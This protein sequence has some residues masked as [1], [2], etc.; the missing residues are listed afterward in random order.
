MTS[1][2]GRGNRTAAA[3]EIAPYSQQ[4]GDF[5]TWVA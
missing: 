3:G 2:V 1:A 5:F 4:V